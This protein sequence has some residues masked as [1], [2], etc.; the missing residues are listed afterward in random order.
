MHVRKD[1]A[2]AH[3]GDHNRGGRQDRPSCAL[4]RPGPGHSPHCATDRTLLRAGLGDAP[5]VVVAADGPP[6]SEASA[7][8]LDA[9]RRLPARYVA[10]L[11]LYY[12]EGQSMRT[13]A[14]AMD[15]PEEDVCDI[16]AR[17]VAQLAS[18]L[19]AG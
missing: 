18:A 4:R 1:V 3:T 9:V 7:I 16:H 8:L 5:A 12:T 19:A 2:G 13:I 11:R 10:V 15:L 17:V 6:C 14:A